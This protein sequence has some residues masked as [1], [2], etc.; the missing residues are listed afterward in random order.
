[1]AST[2]PLNYGG[3]IID[4]SSFTFKDGKIVDFTAKQ[5]YETLKRLIDTDEGARYLGEVALVPH[6]SPI[7]QMNLVF[8]NTLF[9]ENASCHAAIGSAYAFCLEGGK[10]MPKSELGKNAANASIAHADFMI[11]SD[12]LDIDDET[13]D[14]AIEPNFRNGNGAIENHC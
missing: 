6:E 9:D 4:D 14:S 5:G 10:T 3:T 7:A 8:Y 13:H 11:G 12:N 1:V 2:K